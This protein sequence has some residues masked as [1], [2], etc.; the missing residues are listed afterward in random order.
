MPTETK[1]EIG[2]AVVVGN[3]KSY[4]L[5]AGKAYPV[6]SVTGRR[7][8]IVNDNNI[9]AAYM[10][11]VFRNEGKEEA[12]AKAAPKAVVYP[13]VDEILATFNYNIT[14]GNISFDVQGNAVVINAS[15]GNSGTSISCGIRQISGLNDFFEI[16]TEYFEQE[17]GHLPAELRDS[18]IDALFTASVLKFM[19][20]VTSVGLF[21]ASTNTNH[22]EFAR[23]NALLAPYT[24]QSHTCD[25]PNSGNEIKLW[26][27][28]QQFD[29]E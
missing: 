12:I 17:L 20:N 4:A 7:I 2:T 6:I 18:I 11:S 27:L 3:P 25:N 23:I 16:C 22:T 8:T 15:L 29:N 26:V 1:S 28:E 21:L 19:E 13:T 24:V 14:E 9:T 10:A 5:T